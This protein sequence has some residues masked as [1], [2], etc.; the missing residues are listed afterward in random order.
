[1]RASESRDEAEQERARASWVVIRWGQ[2][3]A[4]RAVGPAG[5]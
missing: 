5:Q 3:Q 1:M 4:G 2:A